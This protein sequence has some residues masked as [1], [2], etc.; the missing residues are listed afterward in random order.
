[1]PTTATGRCSATST[2]SAKKHGYPEA[3]LQVE[4]QLGALSAWRLTDG[5]KDRALRDLNFPW[6][7]AGTGQRWRT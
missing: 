7:G 4:G 1:M 6:A 3:H 5:T 2:T